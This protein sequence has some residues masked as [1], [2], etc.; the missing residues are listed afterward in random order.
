[1]QQDHYEKFPIV[2][3]LLKIH[4][5]KFHTENLMKVSWHTEKSGSDRASGSCY[6]N[7]PEY[8]HRNSK[9]DNSG[10]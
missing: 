9:P 6:K 7:E 5:K 4:C 2:K 10:F 3:K 1:M 8:Y